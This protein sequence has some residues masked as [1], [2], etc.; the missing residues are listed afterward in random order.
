MSA[1]SKIKLAGFDLST[2]DSGGLGVVPASKLTD[3][4][5]EFIK[6]NKAEILS[7][8]KAVNDSETEFKRFCVTRN[9][10]SNNVTSPSGTTLSDMRNKFAKSEVE[11]LH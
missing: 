9:G 2:E 3:V 10:V 7:E 11:I 5:R 6:A 1:L 8:L 4:Q